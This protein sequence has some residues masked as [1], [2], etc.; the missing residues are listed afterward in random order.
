MKGPVIGHKERQ[1]KKVL[2]TSKWLRKRRGKMRA[3]VAKS[4]SFGGD[5]DATDMSFHDGE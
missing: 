1:N 4:F 5:I 3:A 2:Y